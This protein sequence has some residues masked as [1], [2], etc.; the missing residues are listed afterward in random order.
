MVQCVMCKAEMSE[1]WQALSKAAI[2]TLRAE[3]GIYPICPTCIR[4]KAWH[5]FGQEPPVVDDVDPTGR[6]DSY[7][8]GD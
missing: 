5:R 7:G 6:C 3:L 8:G 4:K 2:T 1:N